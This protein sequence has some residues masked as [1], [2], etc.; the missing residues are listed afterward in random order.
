MSLA[1]AQQLAI[2][3]LLSKSAYDSTLSPGPPLPKSHPSPALIAKLFLECATLYASARALAKTPGR[4]GDDVAP[5]LRHYLADSSALCNALA[6]KWLGVDGGENGGT[7]QGGIAVAFLG[8]AKSE[9]EDLRDGRRGLG[10]VGLD[11]D[12]RETRGR[13]K[14]RITE[15]LD[16]IVVFWK[17]YKKMNDSLHFQP[18]PPMSELQTLIPA[19]RAA[20]A[21]K[22]FTPPTP[23]FGP[24]SVE[25]ARHQAELLELNSSGGNVGS[26]V[27]GSSQDR[28]PIEQKSTSS[29][30]G[31]GSYF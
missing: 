20:V 23:A 19:G 17:H 25:Y 27:D 5:G 15:E 7:S 26:P 12:K 14:D 22:P 3:K 13:M 8:W 11:K 30:A 4:E 16:G 24:G 1:D 18:V 10:A 2:R 9:L 29:Y 21:F 28:P 31:A 6:H